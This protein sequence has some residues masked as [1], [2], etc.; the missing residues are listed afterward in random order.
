MKFAFLIACLSITT[1]N[2]MD[3]FCDREPQD[4]QQLLEN[5]SEAF[6]NITCKQR[7]ETGL[8]ERVFVDAAQESVIAL[9]LANQNHPSLPEFEQQLD[10]SWSRVFDFSCAPLD[11]IL[12]DETLIQE[13]GASRET[14]EDRI[15]S[16]HVLLLKSPESKKEDPYSQT[17]KSFT[18]ALRKLIAMV[19]IYQTRFPD[20]RG[21]IWIQRPLKFMQEKTDSHVQQWVEKLDSTG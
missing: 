5:T 3:L 16:L 8:V 17:E 11:L 7:K 13:D 9:R 14:L 1:A 21:K 12:S 4:Q 2:A 15:Q 18:P 19:E 6:G 10:N 20:K